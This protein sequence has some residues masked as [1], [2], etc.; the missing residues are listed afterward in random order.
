MVRFTST[1]APA[2]GI[3]SETIIRHPGLMV[4]R[5]DFPP[6]RSLPFHVVSS[7]VLIVVVSGHGQV[8]V[9]DRRV[10]LHSGVVVELLPGERHHIK[11]DDTLEVVLVKTSERH[12][13]ESVERAFEAR[14]HEFAPI[15]RSSGPWEPRSRTAP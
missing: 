1:E 3:R 7:H 12:A 5:L 14:A 10:A 9:N 6:G 15:S 2:T 8:T 13:E 4:V 11:A